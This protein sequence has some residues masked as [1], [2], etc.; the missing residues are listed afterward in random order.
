METTIDVTP[1]WDSA[2]RI[3]LEVLRVNDWES[4]PSKMARKEILQMA[5]ALDNANKFLKEYRKKYDSIK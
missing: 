3:Y 2:T 4:E 5:H 1:T